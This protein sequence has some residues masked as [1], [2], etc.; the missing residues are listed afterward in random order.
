MEEVLIK[1]SANIQSLKAL[2]SALHSGA[3]ASHLEHGI[4]RANK[5]I[6]N[7]GGN[8]GM[9]WRTNLA[10]KTINKSTPLL[11]KHTQNY[12]DYAKALTDTQRK[13]LNRGKGLT[14][15]AYDIPKSLAF[16]PSS[17]MGWIP[18]M[19]LYTGLGFAGIN[20]DPYSR[21]G[22]LHGLTNAKGIA[23]DS[24]M[25]AGRY[26]ADEFI[27]G[28]DSLGFKDRFNA[29]RNPNMFG[30]MIPQEYRDSLRGIGTGKGIQIGELL[31]GNPGFMDYSIR[32]G[33]AGGVNRFKM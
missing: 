14:S 30:E 28:F 19:G 5:L 22:Q 3:R 26:A 4:N 8:V 16:L 13:W 21:A 15:F 2:F 29:A 33:I 9:G 32:D 17:R 27:Q 10:Q 1:S 23:E 6:S 24:A 25:N 31:K 12:D 18:S 7:Y 11:A 20:A